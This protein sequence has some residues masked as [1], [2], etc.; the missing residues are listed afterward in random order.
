MYSRYLEAWVCR[1][2]GSCRKS[3]GV[4]HTSEPPVLILLVVEYSLL[5]GSLYVRAACIRACKAHRDTSKVGPAA[6]PLLL[7]QQARN[8]HSWD[9]DAA[10]GKIFGARDGSRQSACLLHYE[11]ARNDLFVS[12]CRRLR[13]FP[14]GQKLSESCGARSS[15][16]T[17]KCNAGY[18]R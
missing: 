9:G 14:T 8:F 3:R 4:L 12:S 1:G 6:N 18:S 17:M 7:H 15:L 16:A 13:L 11:G 10:T 2:D 5:G